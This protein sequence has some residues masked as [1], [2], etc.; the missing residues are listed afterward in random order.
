MQRVQG[1]ERCKEQRDGGRLNA[2]LGLGLEN[3]LFILVFFFK[4]W[5]G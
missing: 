1:G 2:T 5:P 3:I 4:C